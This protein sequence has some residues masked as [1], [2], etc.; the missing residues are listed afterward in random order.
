MGNVTE[1][2]MMKHKNCGATIQKLDK[3]SYCVLSSGEVKNY[4]HNETRADDKKSVRSSLNRLR[5]IINANVTIPQNCKF[6]TLTYAENMTDR[7]KLYIDRQNY[8]RRFKSYCKSNQIQVPEYISVIEPQGRGAFHLHE[9]LIWNQKAPF[10]PNDDIWKCW[11]PS[12]ITKG[13]DF[14]K[15]KAISDCDNIG[16][17]F[18]A[19]LADMP[20]DEYENLPKNEKPEIQQEVLEKEFSDDEGLTKKKKFIKGGRLHLYPSGINIY[21]ASKGIIYPQYEYT[22]YKKAKEKVSGATE[23]FSQTIIVADD[24]RDFSNEITKSYYNLKRPN[25]Y[26]NDNI[27]K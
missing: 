2:V 12:G 26:G 25:S 4:E 23:T 11:S 7:K 14:T 1:L 22:N 16:A 18:S 15:T 3:D 20:L 10:I 21:R 17:Y 5:S 6:V 13:E 8:W 27:T 19:Y 9:L 24:V